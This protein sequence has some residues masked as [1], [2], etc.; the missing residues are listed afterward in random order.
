TGTAVGASPAGCPPGSS[1]RRT[2]RS[3]GFLPASRAACGAQAA[4]CAVRRCTARRRSFLRP[5]IFWPLAEARR[6]FTLLQ[7]SLRA[8]FRTEVD[9]HFLAE[10]EQ[11]VSH[12]R[13]GEIAASCAGG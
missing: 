6:D 2:A 4:V 5:A 13:V 9:P 7:Q 1:S 11:I 10:G 12:D 3:H 8:H